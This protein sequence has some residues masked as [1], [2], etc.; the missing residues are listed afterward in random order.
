MNDRPT[1]RIK[2]FCK[3]VE[4]G[5]KCDN[6]PQ[7]MC[8]AMNNRGSVFECDYLVKKFEFHW[9][10]NTIREDLFDNN[11]KPCGT[12]AK[13]IAEV[14]RIK[15]IRDCVVSIQLIAPHADDYEIQAEEY[16]Q[17]E[18]RKM[19]HKINGYGHQILISTKTIE[20]MLKE[21]S[22]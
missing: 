7:F 5:E 8:V 6:H 12:S 16:S 1:I 19:L 4:A 14:D 9:G 3:K 18:L 17:E 11:G 2:H 15:N 22:L 21:E 20:D 10:S 13:F